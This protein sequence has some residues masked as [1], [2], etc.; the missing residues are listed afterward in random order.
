MSKFLVQIHLRMC[1]SMKKLILVSVIILL[2]IMCFTVSA[3][4]AEQQLQRYPVSVYLDGEAMN[5]NSFLC[6]NVAYADM[7]AF[8]KASD[9]NTNVIWD[10]QSGIFDACSDKT[11]VNLSISS[12]YLTSNGRYLYLDCAPQIV[13]G[14]LYIPVRT[15]AKI[16]CQY[17]NWNE[18]AECVELISTGEVL[19]NGATYYNSDDLYWLSRII[20]AESREESLLGK[21][22]VGNVVMNRV[23]SPSYPD[24]IYG[25]IFDHRFGVQFTPSVNNTIYKNPTEESVVAAKICLEGYSVTANAIYF[26]N[27]KTATSNWIVN[28]RTFLQTIGNHSFYS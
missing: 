14:K 7:E 9:S 13:D 18:I 17:I 19:E 23:C 5:I 12:D 21:I 2:F 28:N 15:L 6:Q 16:Y 25:V 8:C 22:A 26:L 24:T 27:K 3:N 4:E 11:W 20:S 1:V 10:M